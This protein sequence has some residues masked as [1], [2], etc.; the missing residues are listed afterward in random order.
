MAIS[1]YDSRSLTAA[2]NKIKPPNTQIFDIFNVQKEVHATDIIDW[3]TIS[4][5]S[6]VAQ[7]VSREATEPK[8][9]KRPTR[10]VNSIRIPRTWEAM[11]FTAQKLKDYT[12]LGN[13]YG[14]S[15]QEIDAAINNRVLSDLDSLQ[16]RAIRRRV[17]MFA[18]TLDTGKVVIA[19]D[20]YE[21][22]IESGMVT[23]TLAN[24]GHIVDLSGS[25]DWASTTANIDQQTYQIKQAFTKRGK[26]VRVCILGASA[27]VSFLANEKVRKVLDNNNIQAGRLNIN[28]AQE[29][30]LI[31]LGTFYGIQFY[32]YSEMY[33][34]DSGVIV[35]MINDKRAIF[36]D[37]TA[38]FKM[39]VA[40]VH[41]IENGKV[42]SY[43]SEFY[44]D[45]IEKKKQ[46][47]TWELEQKSL[48]QIK[49]PDSII[50][51]KVVA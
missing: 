5:E 8:G 4:E 49:D 43:Q 45:S 30:T 33:K 11:T 47:L 38:E 39:H 46:I 44:L 29:S 18:E 15:Q 42:V 51:A 40:P 31:P 26:S 14:A 9:I 19:Q 20:D 7:F 16:N 37:N 25:I 21:A 17:Q 13:I 34:N 28:S 35:P 50:S 32:E 22:T 23:D 12:E 1:I 41:R 36:A 27:A 6:R 24:G 2:V 10:T 3:E 48:P